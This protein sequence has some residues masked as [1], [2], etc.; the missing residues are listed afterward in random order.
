M[1]LANDAENF[2]GFISFF[3]VAVI[4]AIRS[5]LVAEV[6]SPWG[7]AFQHRLKKIKLSMGVTR[8]YEM[9]IETTRYNRGVE[10][11]NRLSRLRLFVCRSVAA[12]RS[13][14]IVPE[15]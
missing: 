12:H 14:R 13:S 5:R 2:L 11:F 3:C 10:N 15:T 1:V 8:D 9:R 7:G 4:C 6:S